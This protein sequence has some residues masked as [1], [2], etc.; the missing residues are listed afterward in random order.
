MSDRL[1]DRADEWGGYASCGQHPDFV[2]APE[3]LG[4]ERTEAVQKT[5]A[6]CPVRPECIIANTAPVIAPSSL[7]A[8]GRSAPVTYPSCSIWVAGEWLP[9]RDTAAKRDVLE[10]LK[11]ELHASLPYEYVTRPQGVL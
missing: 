9:D 10:K 1:W 6:G 11:D 8:N 7:R 2:I 3:T 5:C 4:P